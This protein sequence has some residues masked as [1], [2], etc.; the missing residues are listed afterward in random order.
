M[1][2]KI[3][4]LSVLV[5]FAAV[6]AWS[7]VTAWQQQALANELIRLRV[8]AASDADSDQAAKLL[9]RDAVLEAAEGILDTGDR[10]QA[11]AVLEEN[12]DVLGQA[13]VTAL[14]GAGK[15]DSVRAYLT[16][17]S[18]GT[19]RY[20]T[21]TLP[22]GSY[23]TLRVDIGDAEGQNWWCVVFP[24]LCQAAAEDFAAETGLSESEAVFL[25]G[26][27][28]EYVFRFRTLELLEQFRLWLQ[29]RT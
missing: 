22:A 13:A 28:E 12:L 17:E 1:E 5:A 15:G 6:L 8:V 29:R 3:A 14:R 11:A 23:L 21:F 9:V 7:A 25:Q 16:T 24:P 27:E 19:R 26:G 18:A 10:N 4:A 20:G 2:R